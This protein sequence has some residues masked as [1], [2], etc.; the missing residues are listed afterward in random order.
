[1][2]TTEVRTFPSR[3]RLV[4]LRLGPGAD[5]YQELAALGRGGRGPALA[6]VSCVG[7][8]RQAAVRFAGAK[9][10]TALGGPLEIVSL[11]GTIGPDGAHLHICLSDKNGGCV[12]GHLK[13]GSPVYT[14]AEIVLVD[15]T[16]L[17]FERAA[18]A[19]TG[20]PELKIRRR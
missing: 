19:A 3:A 5:L 12:G 10:A 11:V 17:S 14:T 7:S 16:D 13:E 2:K 4:A 8:L 18:D 20:Y 9:Q 15:A 1:M 6:V